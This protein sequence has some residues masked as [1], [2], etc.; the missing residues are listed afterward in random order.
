[1]TDEILYGYKNWREST[2][3]FT[4]DANE[5]IGI[6]GDNYM[7]CM[8]FMFNDLMRRNSDGAIFVV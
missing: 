3:I 2:F 6:S 8:C 1:L 5:E 7:N 4:L